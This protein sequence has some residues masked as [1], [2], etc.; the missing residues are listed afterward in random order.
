MTYL[1]LLFENDRVRVSD[2][3]LPPRGID[4]DRVDISDGTRWQVGDAVYQGGAKIDETVLSKDK[5]MNFE[6]SLKKP[7]PSV[8]LSI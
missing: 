5:H 7:V 3:R 8:R 2:L 4:E 6:K 1:R